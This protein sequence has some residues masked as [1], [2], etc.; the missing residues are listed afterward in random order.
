ME[1]YVQL[2][3]FISYTESS[4]INETSNTFQLLIYRSVIRSHIIYDNTRINSLISTF[5]DKSFLENVYVLLVYSNMI[6]AKVSRLS[7][8]VYCFK[9]YSRI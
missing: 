7:F 8:D 2:N 9:I 3:S 1:C 6:F 5:A 4:K